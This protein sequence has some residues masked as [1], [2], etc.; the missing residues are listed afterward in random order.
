[1]RQ[2]PP[3]HKNLNEL[4]SVLA[5]ISTGNSSHEDKKREQPIASTAPPA[6]QDETAKPRD[7]KSALAA[8]LGNAA[9]TPLPRPQAENP[10]SAP[11]PPPPPPQEA[12]GNGDLDPKKLE[13]MMRVSTQ[14]K[15]PL[16]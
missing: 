4:R 5:R 10:A 9:E 15:S 12:A 3:A 11:T 2:A 7:L 16:K 14:D 13:P 6:S 1:M 8:A